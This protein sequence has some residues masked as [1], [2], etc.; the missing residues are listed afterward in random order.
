VV[1]FLSAWSAHPAPF[2]LLKDL[3]LQSTDV[4]RVQGVDA[5]IRERTRKLRKQSVAQTAFAQCRSSR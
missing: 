3:G 4:A 5:R 2:D 1:C